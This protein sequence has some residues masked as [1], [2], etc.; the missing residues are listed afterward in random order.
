M[1]KVLKEGTSEGFDRYG[2]YGE[3]GRVYEAK[4]KLLEE[5]A[6]NLSVRTWM[7]DGREIVEYL[8]TDAPE[9]EALFY[10]LIGSQVPRSFRVAKG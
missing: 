4:V 1:E 6:G 2:I 10:G 8:G 9:A 3:A 5:E 7:P